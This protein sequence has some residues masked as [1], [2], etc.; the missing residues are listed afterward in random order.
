MS[1]CLCV[2]V[3]AEGLSISL[4]CFIR[5]YHFSPLVCTCYVCGRANVYKCKY[6]PVT[7][8]EWV[9]EVNLRCWSSFP[10]VTETRTPLFTAVNGRQA[11]SCALEVLLCLLILP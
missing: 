10:T 1:T 3:A 9:S 2:H 5:Y 8:Q 6:I 11:G 7:G 4:N